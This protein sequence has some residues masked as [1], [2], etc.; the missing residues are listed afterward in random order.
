MW[1]LLVAPWLLAV[2]L[3]VCGSEEEQMAAGWDPRVLGEQMWEL[4]RLR[5]LSCKSGI[6]NPSPSG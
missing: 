4:S 3:R 5:W 6:R 1:D 2:I